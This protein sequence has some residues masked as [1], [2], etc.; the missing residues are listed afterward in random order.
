MYSKQIMDRFFEP[1][2]SGVIRAADGVGKITSDVGNEIVK[3]YIKVEGGKVADAQFQTFGGVVAIALSSFA[4]EYIVGKNV[5]DLE[6]FTQNDLL[7]IS[8]EIPDESFYVAGLVVNAVKKAALN[9]QNK[10]D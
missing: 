4:A 2:N 1:K 5:S 8:G 3:I 9:Y 10:N 6:K 7:K